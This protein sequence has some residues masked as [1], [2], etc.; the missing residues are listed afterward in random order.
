MAEPQL[1]ILADKTKYIEWIAQEFAPLELAT[2]QATVEQQ[3]DNAVRY[4]NTHSAYK[5]SQMVP[6]VAG[7]KRAQVSSAFK[8]V[9]MV[10]PNRS[11][12]WI[13]NEYP[14]WS[15]AGIAVLDNIRTDL[16][17]ATEA[18]KTFNIYV[19]ANF[20]WYFDENHDDFLEDSNE[21][22]FR[23]GYLYCR[24]VPTGTSALFVMGTKRILP[25]DDIKS[26]HIN[27]WL[28][29][30]T[31]ALVKQI[32]GNTLRKANIVLPNGLDGNQLVTEGKEEMKALQKQIVIESR[33]VAFFR[34]Q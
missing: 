24:N 17:L 11:A 32:E 14:T 19:G 3:V 22:T 30:Y 23:G 31:K 9:A 13:W 6:Y 29:Y 15:L 20:R 33:W 4:W 21:T 26:E 2:P 28:L 27:N 12:N 7:Q 16:I 8:S 10:Y 34:R 1:A 5:I 18:F 25:N